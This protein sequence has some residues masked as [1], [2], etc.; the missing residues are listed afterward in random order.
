MSRCVFKR[1]G[2]ANFIR[3]KCPCSQPGA[4]VLEQPCQQEGQR[5][6]QFNGIVEFKLLLEYQRVLG[7]AELPSG[8]PLRQMLQIRAFGSKPRR[9]SERRK[10]GQCAQSA[11]APGIE[12]ISGFG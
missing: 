4:K 9:D 3:R 1:E 11:D 12:Q 6:Q 10:S 2:K 5:L 7:G 8:A